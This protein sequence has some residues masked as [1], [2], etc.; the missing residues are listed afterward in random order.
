MTIYKVQGPEG[1][2]LKVEGPEGAS[3]QEVVQFAEQQYYASLPPD[4]TFGELAGKSFDRGLERFK[5]TYGDVLP[6]MVGSALGFDD[7]AKRQ[8]EEARQSEEYI[9]RTMRPQ[10]ASFRDVNWANPIDISKFIVETTG[11]QVVN[12]A[13]VLVPGGIGA[14]GGEMLLT[15][16][17][18]KTL[19][20]KITDKAQKKSIKKIKNF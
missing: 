1:K 13:G 17:A 19:A 12:L 6:A 15:N 9:Q 4:Y 2:I 20:P 14:K 11:E 3:E 10:F 5:S 8:M 16:K 7:Y 18:L